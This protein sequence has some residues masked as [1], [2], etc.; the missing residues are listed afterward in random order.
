MRDLIAKIVILG[1]KGSGKSALSEVAIN[2]SSDI[3]NLP[4]TIDAMYCTINK[5]PLGSD[6]NP[7]VKL[8]TW[9]TSGDL[10][11]E[12]I[13]T[14]YI[15]GASCVIITCDLTSRNSF[16]EVDKWIEHA[17]SFAPNTSILL[18]GTKSDLTDERVITK[19]ELEN[20]AKD[21]GCIGA[22]E[23]SS[24]N[25]EGVDE[26]FQKCADAYWERL[27]PAKQV[28]K[29]DS[30]THSHV[31]I[32]QRTQTSPTS[33]SRANTSTA[34]THVVEANTN[35]QATDYLTTK[36][37]IK[38]VDHFEK[39]WNKKLKHPLPKAV[40]QEAEKI[41]QLLRNYAK[42]N[43]ILSIYWLTRNH[44]SDIDTIIKSYNSN[45]VNAEILKQQLD[46][47]TLKKSDGT[48]AAL[49]HFVDEK[50]SKK[51]LTPL[52][53]GGAPKPSSCK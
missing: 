8:Q 39:H 25:N 28:K 18:V 19:K 7:L 5:F 27:H 1:S 24:K 11:Y 43:K 52:K 4:A 50:L 41:I 29:N 26:V 15:N 10:C 53:I 33:E 37:H 2:P 30:K 20:K 21:S 12:S 38:L 13:T 46:K 45:P 35:I 31:N 3:D 6:K 40:D 17:K 49:I 22:M 32:L 44:V 48:L 42:F 14:S 16:K 36:K 34:P 51:Q 47:L 9:D 23:T